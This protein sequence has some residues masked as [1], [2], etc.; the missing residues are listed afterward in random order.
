MSSLDVL[1]RPRAVAVIGASRDRRSVGGAI[2]H[3]LLTFEFQGQV[4]PVNPNAAVV[5]SLK[6]YASVEDIPDAVDLA[7]IAVPKPHVLA[8]SSRAAASAS[9]PSS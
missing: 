3:N 4:F 5:H 6:C 2:L 1:F 9:A 8:A 7:V